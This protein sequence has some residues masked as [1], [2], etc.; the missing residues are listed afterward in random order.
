MIKK[1]ISDIETDLI[2]NNSVNRKS[3]I[4]VEELK[5]EIQTINY[6]WLD[7]GVTL[8]NHNHPD[9]SE[10]YLFIEGEGEMIINEKSIKITKDDFIIVEKNENH[11][12]INREE[13][14]LT[15][16]TIRVLI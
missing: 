4:K 14:K 2:H 5:G 3:L 1:N 16:I 15:F 13:Q 11:S 7:Q 8:E 6:A 9:C 12:L 10:C